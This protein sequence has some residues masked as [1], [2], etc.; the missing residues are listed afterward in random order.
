MFD[1]KSIELLKRMTEAFG[2][3]GFER[4]VTRIVKEYML[5]YSDGVVQDKLGSVAFILRGSAERP[6]I[7]LAGHVDE[8]GFAVS[9]IDE[10]TGFL[11]FSTIGGWWDQ[12]L[13]GQ[14]VVVRTSKGDLMGVIASKPPHILSKE[15]RE[16][17][18]KKDEMYIDIGVTSKE[19]AEKLGVK[20]GDPVTPWSPF[21]LLRDGRVGMGKAFDDRLG[22]FV[23]LEACRRIKEQGIQHP[24]T[25]YAAATVQEEVGLRGAKTIAHVVDPDVGI[26]LEIDIC[27][28]VPG[29]DSRKAPARMGKGPTLVTMDGSMIPNQPFKEFVIKVAEECKIPLQLS[30]VMGGGTDAGRIHLH[31][32]GCPTVVLGVPT[33]HI[34]SHVGLFS[35][36]DAEN[37]VRLL[38]ELLKRLD[39]KT[40]ESFL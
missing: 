12:V 16:K 33:R 27:G 13:L 24:N 8:V 38:I 1:T 15:E 26:V 9:G 21:M 2:P 25:I 3:S 10:K 17:L 28:D 22:T 36:E 34:H 29:V 18:V 37:G 32:S 39:Q 14:R 5:P 4:E 19:E 7:L 23:M 40:V 30:Q 20:I 11:S 6:R 35:L 31:G